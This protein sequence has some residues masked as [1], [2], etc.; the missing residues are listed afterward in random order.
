VSTFLNKR[1]LK[2][3]VGDLLSD[4]PAHRKETKLDIPA[5]R[6]ADDLTIDYVRGPIRLSRTKEGIL[7][8]CEFHIGLSDECYRCLDKVERDI[9]INVEEL[10]SYHSKAESEFK[11]NEDHVLDLGPLIRAEVFIEAASGVLCRPDCKGLC[12][13]CGA[14][15]N[16]ETCDC[17]KN[18]I[19]PQFEALK[20]LLDS[21]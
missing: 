12:T 14:N 7:V 3:N 19:N 11:I 21:E 15:L 10:F 13:E 8:Q 1:V 6:V 4:G 2:L 5:V 18:A 9:Q 17:H 16:I 20:K